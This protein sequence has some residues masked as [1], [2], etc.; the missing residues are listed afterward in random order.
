VFDGHKDK[1]VWVNRRKDVED[2]S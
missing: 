1:V 2:G